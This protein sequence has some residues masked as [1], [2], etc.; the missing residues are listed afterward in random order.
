MP[1]LNQL[2]SRK[3]T[4]VVVKKKGTR[5]KAMKF[6]P[7]RKG[8][9]FKVT[10]MKPKKPNSAQRKIAK[11]NLMHPRRR[12]TCYIPGIGGFEL[13]NYSQV[14]V[15]GGHVCDLPGVQYHLI[16]GKFDLTW[17]EEVVR[18][19]ARSKYSIPRDSGQ[20]FYR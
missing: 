20:Q 5:S 14:L 6:R 3:G 8:V 10:T 4:R 12:V 19:F 9:C 18:K 17:R 11:V 15:R 2:L 7:Q 16:R 13:K 1:T